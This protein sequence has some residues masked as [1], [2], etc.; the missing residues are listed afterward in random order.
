VRNMNTAAQTFPLNMVAGLFGF[1]SAQYFNMDHT[2]RA[3][4]SVDV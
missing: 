3:A 1:K 4:P 2:E